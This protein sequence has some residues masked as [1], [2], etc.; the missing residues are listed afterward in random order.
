MSSSARDVT[1]RVTVQ[2]E[3]NKCMIR[4]PV[5]SYGMRGSWNHVYT[6]LYMY[7]IL[8]LFYGLIYESRWT[9]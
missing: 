8:L 9:E 3:Y 2:V 4:R 7:C 6:T 1:V 5:F